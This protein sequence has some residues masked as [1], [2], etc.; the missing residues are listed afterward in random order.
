MLII[1]QQELN[2]FSIKEDDKW[3]YKV[4]SLPQALK[5]VKEYQEQQKKQ[6]KIK[7]VLQKNQ[8]I[9]RKRKLIC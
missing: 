3:L 7:I 1:E 8:K 6:L 4:F 9:D 5:L 2:L